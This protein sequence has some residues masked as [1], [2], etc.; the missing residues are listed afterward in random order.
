M[1]TVE[2]IVGMVKTTEARR[3]PLTG[4]RVLELGHYIAAPFCTRLLGDLGAEIIKVEPPGSGDPIREWGELV[5][6]Q[7]PWW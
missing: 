5:N 7:S 6:G 4:L 2:G 3:G 1:T